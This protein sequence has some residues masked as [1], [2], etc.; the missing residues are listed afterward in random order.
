M[1]L[2]ASPHM[3]RAAADSVRGRDPSRGRFSAALRVGAAMAP[4]LLC[5]YAATASAGDKVESREEDSASSSS[6]GRCYPLAD[7]KGSIV[8]RGG[9]LVQLTPEQFQFAR[10]MYV[11]S[12]SGPMELPPGDRAMVGEIPDGGAGV[13][14]VDGESA[15]GL[16]FLGASSLRMLLAVGRGSV[17]HVGKAM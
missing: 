15:C 9:T 10:G 11:V 14:F 3:Q 13:V 1:H 4:L 6:V 7:L 2:F 17:L 12:E 8:S 16:A 5:A